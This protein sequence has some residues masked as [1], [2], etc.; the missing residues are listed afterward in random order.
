MAEK[1]FVTQEGLDELRAELENL[2]HVVR[3]EVIVELQEARAQGDLSE[4]ADYDAA[5]DH[6]ARVE[7]RIKEL[8]SLI[9]NAQIIEEGEGGTKTVRLGS[10]VT[11]KDNTDGSLMTFSI[12]G[13]IEADPFNNK[14]SN[15]TPLVKAILDKRPGETVEVKGV[16]EPYEVTIES[17][18]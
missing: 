1:I 5:R 17:V 14:I 6:Q 3:P 12:V 18:R 2:V 7:G 15:E 10:T 13:T 8:E 9:K 11:I 4:N 16:E